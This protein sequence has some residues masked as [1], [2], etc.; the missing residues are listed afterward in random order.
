[1]GAG[2]G[3]VVRM[4]SDASRR[5]APR[6]PEAISDD[7]PRRYRDYSKQIADEVLA[8]RSGRHTDVQGAS[9]RI[10]TAIAPAHPLDDLQAVSLENEPTLAQHTPRLF[11]LCARQ[12]FAAAL[13]IRRVGIDTTRNLPLPSIRQKFGCR[14]RN[15]NMIRWFPRRPLVHR[16]RQTL[17]RRDLPS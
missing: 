10:P 13:V 15:A 14:G 11:E 17:E 9:R 12:R 16:T 8:R 2:V 3:C 4:Q 5:L 6:D 1:V 7:M